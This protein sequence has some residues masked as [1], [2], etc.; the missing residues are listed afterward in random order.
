MLFIVFSEE[1]SEGA[2]ITRISGRGITALSLVVVLLFVKA[3]SVAYTYCNFVQEETMTYY[4]NLIGNIQD[5]EGYDDGLPVAFLNIEGTNDRT[6]TYEGRYE[7]SL[8]AL[9][10]DM[11]QVVRGYSYK[12][13]LALHCGYSPV[14]ISGD[15]LEQIKSLK[16]V[17][18][19]P[20]YPDDGSIAVIDHVIVVKFAEK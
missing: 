14:F 7:V 18:E 16:E 5:C 2:V 11:R 17:E 4:T 15:E 13:Y 10:F 1:Y 12:Q 8:M 20:C 6:M 9:G 3:D 19:M